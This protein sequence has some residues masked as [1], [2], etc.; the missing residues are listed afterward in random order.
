MV[1]LQTPMAAA[2]KQAIRPK[3]TIAMIQTALP[4]FFER[5]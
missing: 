5:E 3:L 2:T 4:Q 1:L